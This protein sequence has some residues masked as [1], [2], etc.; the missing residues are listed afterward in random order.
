MSSDPWQADHPPPP[1]QNRKHN[2]IDRVFG[3]GFLWNEALDAVADVY[4]G[5]SPLRRKLQTQF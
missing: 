3:R 5:V 1:P 2:P 4:N